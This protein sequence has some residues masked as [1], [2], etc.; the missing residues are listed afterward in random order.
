MTNLI[1]LVENVQRDDEQ[2]LSINNLQEVFSCLIEAANKWYN[3]GLALGIENYNLKNIE[4]NYNS[5]D[6][7]LRIM[8]TCWLQ[9]SLSRTWTD[10]C[11][12][13]R[14]DTVKLIALA[15]DIEKKYCSGG[16]VLIVYN[17]NYTELYKCFELKCI[18]IK[19]NH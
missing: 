17:F 14:S 1:I 3:L 9:S 2:Q 12:G 10:I 13:L 18:P 19:S 7:F 8:L 15:E 6:I 4:S 16:I 11:N 5:N